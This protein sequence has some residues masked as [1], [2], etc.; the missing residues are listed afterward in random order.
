MM[1]FKSWLMACTSYCEWQFK[2]L[3]LHTC[4]DTEIFILHILANKLYIYLFIFHLKRL[5]LPKWIM[6][7]KKQRFNLLLN[8]FNHGCVCTYL[9]ILDRICGFL[10]TQIHKGWQYACCECI[11]SAMVDIQGCTA[12]NSKQTESCLLI[13]S[14]P[15][16]NQYVLYVSSEWHQIGAQAY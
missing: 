15:I 14:A 1:I 8:L 13:H 10:E 7:T 12:R 2:K 11:T 3:I 6:K 5:L 9:H 4:C 16:P